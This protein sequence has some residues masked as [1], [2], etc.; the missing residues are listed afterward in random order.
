M[1]SV[2]SITKEKTAKII[3]NAIAVATATE[4]HIFTSFISRDQT[5]NLIHKAWKKALERSDIHPVKLLF[6]RNIFLNILFQDDMED[7]VD[8]GEERHYDSSGSETS[9]IASTNRPSSS[10]HSSY[11]RLATPSSRSQQSLIEN[12]SHMPPSFFIMLVLI[13]LLLLLLISSI[14]L[15]LKL[16]H[17]EGRMEIT[18][19]QENSDFLSNWQNLLSSR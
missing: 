5:Y 11:R 13:M 18:V 8:G 7:A 19:P 14:Y 16:D 12:V 3:P 4:K 2:T 6:I 9:D 1:T 17:L 15:L 10:Q